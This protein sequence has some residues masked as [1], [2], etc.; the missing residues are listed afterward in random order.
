MI[1]AHYDRNVQRLKEPDEPRQNQ[2]EQEPPWAFPNSLPNP[3][4]I[5]AESRTLR[6]RQSR[7]CVEFHAPSLAH[8]SPHRPRPRKIPTHRASPQRPFARYHQADFLPNRSHQI[9]EPP[10]SRYSETQLLG[11][12][13]KKSQEIVQVPHRLPQKSL[14]HLAVTKNLQTVSGNSD[15]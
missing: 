14:T 6:T 9:A 15:R 11:L 3:C 13:R 7:I 8:E 10:A 4:R 12:A 5:N 1:Y 2:T